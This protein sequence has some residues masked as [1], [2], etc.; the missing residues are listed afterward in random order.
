MFFISYEDWKDIFS[1]LFIN[2][3]FPEDWTGI[4]FKS[5][6]TKCNSGG[7]P[8]KH[9]MPL[10]E[11]YAKNPQFLVTPMQDTEFMFSL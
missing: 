4:R 7:L 6:W 9:E 10:L 5:A 1:T 3:D 2:L 8:A 11:Q